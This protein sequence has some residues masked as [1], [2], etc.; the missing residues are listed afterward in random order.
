MIQLLPLYFFVAGVLQVYNILGIAC[1]NYAT[2]VCAMD[3]NKVFLLLGILVLLAV[4]LGFVG[5]RSIPKNM[6]PVGNFDLQRYLGTWYEIA[7]FDFTFERNLSQVTAEY[8][9]NKDG[10]VKVVNRGFNYAKNDWQEAVGRARFRGSPTV[11]AL[12]VSF[13]GPFYGGYNIIALDE[14]YQ[15]ALVVGKELNY[16]WILSRTTTMP[17]D[18]LT[19]YLILAESLGFDIDNLVWTLHSKEAS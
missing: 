6:E 13:F 15:Y 2:E 4:G 8:S 18:I 12:E 10:S 5:C 17:S 19:E 9:M 1:P 3:K 14:N 16:L 11:G 7:R